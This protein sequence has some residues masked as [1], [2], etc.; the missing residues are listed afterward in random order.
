MD[1]IDHRV[2]ESDTTERLSLSLLPH[3]PM[4]RV[5]PTPHQE[6]EAAGTS[7]AGAGVWSSPGRTC[8]RY[9]ERA[10]ALVSLPLH[11]SR[12]LGLCLLSASGVLFSQTQSPAACRPGEDWL[13]HQGGSR[14]TSVPGLRGPQGPSPLPS[15]H[16]C[17][18]P[19]DPPPPLWIL[20]T[21]HSHLV[22]T[23]HPGDGGSGLQSHVEINVSLSS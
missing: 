19:H 17:P 9:T 1:Y 3:A 10:E 23:W 4:L 14:T 2:A 21:R 6:D 20:V 12:P 13:R 5:S 22:Q 15:A 18:H 11:A 8:G 7:P 16:T